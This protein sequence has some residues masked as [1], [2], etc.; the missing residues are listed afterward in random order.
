MNSI[1]MRFSAMVGIGKNGVENR[2]VWSFRWQAG[3]KLECGLDLRAAGLVN[4]EKGTQT[5]VGFFPVSGKIAA[6]LPRHSKA[7]PQSV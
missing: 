2:G 4:R 5:Y 7:A 3:R 1:Y 6:R